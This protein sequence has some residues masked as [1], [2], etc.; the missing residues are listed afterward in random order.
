MIYNKRLVPLQGCQ[1]QQVWFL[2]RHGTRYPETEV[3]EQMNT[4][5]KALHAK[6]LRLAEANKGE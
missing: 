1:V 5:G 4:T 3:L 2:F 6:L